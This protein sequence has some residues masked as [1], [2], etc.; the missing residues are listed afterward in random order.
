AAQALHTISHFALGRF[1]VVDEIILDLLI[2]LVVHLRVLYRVEGFFL[3]LDD[4]LQLLEDVELRAL[5]L[6]DQ[7]RFADD[8]QLDRRATAR[9][10]CRIDV[11]EVVGAHLD[12]DQVP[13]P[14]LIAQRPD[15]V[16]VEF[17]VTQPEVWND[18]G[19][20]AEQGIM[21]SNRDLA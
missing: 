16:D 6:A 1:G 8:A 15:H 3:E 5:D 10:T 13:F 19:K 18:G 14:E 17:L 7:L 11:A 4:F 9:F 20:T 12:D 21:A 2:N